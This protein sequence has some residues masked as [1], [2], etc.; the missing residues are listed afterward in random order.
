MSHL[1]IFDMEWNMGYRP[2]TFNYCGVE[3][4]LRGEIIQIG[5]VKLEGKKIIDRFSVI[6][7]P[8][9]FRKLHHHVAKVTGLTQKQVSQGLSIGDGLQRFREWCGEDAILGEW[10]HDDV[11]V[12]KQNLVLQGQDESWPARWVDL[13]KV[14][15]LQHPLQEG[16]GLAL[17]SVVE[18]LGIENR[19]DF[20]DALADAFYTAE[21]MQTVDLEAGL[22]NYPSEQSQLHDL[23]F[24]ENRQR[25]DFI[26][27]GGYADG[28]A[29]NVD[30][31]IRTAVCPQ[32][33]CP[34]IPDS[35]DLWLSRGN[36]CMYSMG[37]C[38]KHGPTM[39]WLRRSCSDGLH[40][41]FARA[42][43]KADEETVNKW[44]HDKKTVLERALRK[45]EKENRNET[46]QNRKL[47][48]AH[49]KS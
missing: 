13:Q 23:L 43:E 5:A 15:T 25:Y 24:P 26:S 8:T 46:D 16:E 47:P 44:T 30:P 12:L 31:V 39:V 2:R 36:N 20:H 34:L 18:R 40:Y 14:Y 49:R 41:M 11:P 48:A 4:V 22:N 19:D 1:V 17:K 6:L 37:T 28:G 35:D 10:G 38:K 21:V 32:C 29:W 33:G 9:I 7:R 45:Q 42:T 27:W 3:Q